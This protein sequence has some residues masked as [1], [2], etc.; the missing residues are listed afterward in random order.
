MKNKYEAW[1]WM[2]FYFQLWN[3]KVY[4]GFISVCNLV[5]LW[6][7]QYYYFKDTGSFNETQTYAF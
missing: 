3:Y 7:F 4:F 5:I 1:N 6:L 2:L